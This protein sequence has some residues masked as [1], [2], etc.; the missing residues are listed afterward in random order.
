[1]D[2]KQVLNYQEIQ[3]GEELETHYDD[4]Y[5]KKVGL[6]API[7][8]GMMSAAY[9]SQMLT[10]YFGLDWIKGGKLSFTFIRPVYTGDTLTC[11]GLVK[12]RTSEGSKADL[13][14]EVWCENQDGEKVTVGEAA[15][16]ISAAA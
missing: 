9:L 10:E 11:R 12:E 5:A 6:P 8:T 13:T 3:I 1:M 16:S 15:L 7:A 4:E 2:D 14:L